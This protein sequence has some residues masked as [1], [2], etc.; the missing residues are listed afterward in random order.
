MLIAGNKRPLISLYCSL[1]HFYA[2]YHKRCEAL[3]PRLQHTHDELVLRAYYRN[4]VIGLK[5][6]FVCPK[7]TTDAVEGYGC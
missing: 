3:H 4:C 6:S 2:L 1:L 5:S 7:N